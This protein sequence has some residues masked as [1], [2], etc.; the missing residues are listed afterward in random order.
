MTAH[1]DPFSNSYPQH[2][3]VDADGMRQPDDEASAPWR[4]RCGDETSGDTYPTNGESRY[5]PPA[6]PAI[7]RRSPAGPVVNVI[8]PKEP[9]VLSQ[10]AA[11]ALLRIL[12]KA[13]EKE[14]MR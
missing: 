5:P 1:D 12:I 3:P 11:R 10:A 14:G 8:T 4:S 6:P 2:V 9:P 7:H 13:A